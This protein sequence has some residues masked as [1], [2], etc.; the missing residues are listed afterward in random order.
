MLLAPLAALLLSAAPA[1]GDTTLADLR[2]SVGQIA[3][4]SGARV[5]V[6]V[7]E[8]ETG[9]RWSLHG[10]EAFPLQSVFKLPLAI[11]VLARADAGTLRLSTPVRVEQADLRPGYSPI[12][13][14]YPRGGVTFTV[15]ELVRR[16]VGESDNTAAD[17]LLNQV[18]G[19]P[20][21]TRY[22]VAAGVHGFR[23]DRSEGALALDLYGLPHARG[24][25]ARD[26]FAARAAR[27]TPAQRRAAFE[28]YLRDPRD[29][30]TPDAAATLL[31]LLWRRRPPLLGARSTEALLRMMT[32]TRTGP[33]RLR[34]LL[35][36]GTP[37]AHKT[38]TS[39]VVEGVA[40]VVNDIGIVT[41]P[42]GRHV[43]I[44]V[45]V[46]RS[47]RGTEAAERAIA[48]ISRAVYD[49]YAARRQLR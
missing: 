46:K 23:V 33:A 10:A 39:G 14:Q 13:D 6:G 47:G 26:V 3:D 21:V 27:Q 45:L 15:G 12:A 17:L 25:E 35:P 31:A 20:A 28:A 30:A 18:G 16:A 34:G 9:E 42:N 41:L 1:P 32:E 49:H 44:A 37:V 29:T 22:L 4:Q 36:P 48:R 19:P 2:R 24:H 5:G 40:G 11:A 38:G 8:L 43:V 7:I